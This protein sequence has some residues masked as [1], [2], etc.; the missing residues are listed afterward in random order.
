MFIESIN[1]QLRVPKE[2]NVVNDVP[3]DMSLLRNC[4]AI[5]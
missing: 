5:R 2:R 4:I 1:P 3:S